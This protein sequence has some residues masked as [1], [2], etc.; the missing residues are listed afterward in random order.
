MLLYD[1]IPDLSLKDRT[2]LP[3]ERVF[4]KIQ[5]FVWDETLSKF[6]CLPEV[7]DYVECFTGPNIRAVHSMLINKPPDSGNKT[8][9]HPLHQVTGYP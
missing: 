3:N 9:R 5:D 1:P 2:G 4:N 7:L 8:S 6:V